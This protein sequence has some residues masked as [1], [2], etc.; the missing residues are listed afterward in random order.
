MPQLSFLVFEIYKEYMLI[1]SG[2]GFLLKKPIVYLRCF[3]IIQHLF[4]SL[5]MCILFS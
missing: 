4:R 2:C 3:L 5:L 1:K